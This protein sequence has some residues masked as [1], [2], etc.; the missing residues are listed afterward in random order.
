MSKQFLKKRNE[1]NALYSKSSCEYRL[2][3]EHKKKSKARSLYD[4]MS[5]DA[6]TS[7]GLLNDES[8]DDKEELQ[9]LPSIPI[10][11]YV[12]KVP[13]AE[14]KMDKGYSIIKV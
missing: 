1:N 2:R 13:K 3:F 14:R 9:V 4:P 12:S 11:G 10:R 5:K 6:I 7:N 8:Q